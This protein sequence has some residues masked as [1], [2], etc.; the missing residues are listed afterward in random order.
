M[1]VLKVKAKSGIPYLPD[2]PNQPNSYS[3]PKNCLARKLSEMFA[4]AGAAPWFHTLLHYDE[5]NNKSTTPIIE[6]LKEKKLKVT[7]AET[8]FIRLLSLLYHTVASR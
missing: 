6:E 1:P 3:L 8:A 2:T 7:N 4:L 5:T